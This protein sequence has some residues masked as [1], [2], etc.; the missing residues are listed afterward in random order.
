MAK[1][2]AKKTLSA[3]EQEKVLSQIQQED[4]KKTVQRLT[5]DL[6]QFIYDKIKDETEETG[7]TMKGFFLWLLNKHFNELESAK[8]R[9]D[10]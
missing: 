6:P 7:Q 3:Q 1:I 5:L 4:K 2:T 8:R 10:E 9:K